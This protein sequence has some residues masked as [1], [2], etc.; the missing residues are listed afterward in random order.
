MDSPSRPTDAQR[1][2]RFKNSGD[3]RIPPFAIVGPQLDRDDAYDAIEANDEVDFALRLGRASAASRQGHDAAL[4]YLNGPQP[5][6][7][8]RQGRCTQT[9]MMQAMIGYETDSPPAWGD[10]LAIDTSQ[11][12]TPFYLVA[13]A[14]AYKFVDFDGCPKTTFKDSQR[15]G[16]TFKIGWIV[17][18][19]QGTVLDGVIIK[20]SS[21]LAT[22]EPGGILTFDGR[23]NP[24]LVPFGLSRSLPY[25][26]ETESLQARGFHRI[27]T[28]GNYL[29]TFTARI[30]S[31]E[32]SINTNIPGNLSLLCRTNRIGDTDE[33]QTA[34][35]VEALAAENDLDEENA[36]FIFHKL[37]VS[38]EDQPADT[39]L[40]EEEIT[41]RHRH[42]QTV[43]GSTVLDLTE[44]ELLFIYNPTSYE[45]EVS[46]VSATLVLLS[47]AG[48]GSGA[49]S[50]SSDSSSGSGDSGGDSGGGGD[51]T[52]LDGRVT[53]LETDVGTLEG[54]VGTLETTVSSQGVTISAHTVSIATNAS[55]IS[56]NTGDIAA[57]DTRID[58]LETFETSATASISTNSDDIATNATDIATNAS[59]IGDLESFEIA[60]TASILENAGDIDD[61]ETFQATTE[62]VFAGA[63]ADDTYQTAAGDDLTFAGGI[64]T[65][66]SQGPTKMPPTN[67]TNQYLL[68]TDGAGQAAWVKGIHQYWE[69]T[70]VGFLAPKVHNTYDVGTSSVRPR[71]LWIARN[72]TIGNSLTVN[73]VNVVSYMSG[74]AL[75]AAQNASAIS[76]LE[77][78]HDNAVPVPHHVGHRL[79]P[80]NTEPYVTTD[81]TGNTV[82]YL[83]PFRDNLARLYTGSAWGLAEISSLS[84][85]LTSDNDVDAASIASSSAY[86]VF[87]DYNGGSPQLALKKWT[88]GGFGSSSRATALTRQ[89]GVWV[90]TGATDHVW[91]GSI[92]T[93][94]STQLDLSEGKLGIWNYYNQMLHR[95]NVFD[96]TS[97]SYNG[98]YRAWNNDTSLRV[99]FILG[100][101]QNIEVMGNFAAWDSTANHGGVQLD[102]TTGTPIETI[103]NRNNAYYRMAFTCM[104]KPSEG[105]HY[106]QCM[107]GTES[108][109]SV[110]FY[111]ARLDFGILA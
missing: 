46:S 95:L 56:T 55:D 19:S 96:D 49:S 68:K 94:S 84:F 9:G 100:Q 35:Q 50:S 7:P 73:G 42:W 70:G 101:K 108:G 58:D 66:F 43:S 10:G 86:D 32:T 80:S 44:G 67:G 104:V 93:N 79:T 92:Y 74:T 8:A 37:R 25:S 1:W 36:D 64:L 52:E 65:G 105:N 6:D 20:D 51:T 53:T 77:D 91:V 88:S 89:D 11:E 2:L 62:A 29:L 31:S 12:E 83:L 72:A 111:E 22:L 17:P 41:E 30:R 109:G 71:D 3:E 60:A 98:G 45:M 59:D 57:H 16:Y 14:G 18:T 90:L 110:N 85:D 76:D 81:D 4:F 69:E 27:N 63:I 48:G 40:V 78:L 87:I 13:G 106:L 97:H 5:V 99:E 54:N 21:T 39:N 28:T 103:E 38:S 47:G 107:E 102:A 26:S 61:L 33:F 34:D 75:I 24:E 15:K 23:D 82:L